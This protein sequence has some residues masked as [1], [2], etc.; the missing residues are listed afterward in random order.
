MSIV[1]SVSSIIV[2]VA[3]FVMSFPHSSVKV[4]VTVSVP[5]APQSSLNPVL[6]WVT[7]AV[8]HSS[9]PEKLANQFANAVALVAGS[10]ATLVMSLGSTV[11]VGSTSSSTSTTKLQVEL[12]PFFVTTSVKV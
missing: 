8:P 5:V 4:N 6:L 11:H 2:K 7:V 1:G 12:Q 9:V 3:S 10:Q